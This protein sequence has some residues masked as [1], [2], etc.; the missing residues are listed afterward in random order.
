VVGEVPVQAGQRWPGPRGQG[1]AARV[2]RGVGVAGRPRPARGVDQPQEPRAVDLLRLDPQQVPVAARADHAVARPGG[3][4]GLQR[5]AQAADIGVHRGVR[6][7]RSALPPH[8]RDQIVSGDGPAEVEQQNGQHGPLFAGT[9][10]DLT[11]V[12][13]RAYGSEDLKP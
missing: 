2:E 12:P 4:V 3:P 11:L 7:R 5:V 1:G 10:V 8:R 9:D 6:R 13:P